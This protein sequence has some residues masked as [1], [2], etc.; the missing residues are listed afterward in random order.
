M[1]Q[2]LDRPFGL[3]QDLGDLEIAPVSYTH[4]DV[5]KRQDEDGEAR[6]AGTRSPGAA[7]QPTV[8]PTD[9]TQIVQPPMELPTPGEDPLE[10]P[11][12][13]SVEEP[14]TPNP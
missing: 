11:G 2:R 14:V 7:D 5:Y 13:I 12:A 1:L 4:L 10:D 8:E 3:A 9:D 6:L